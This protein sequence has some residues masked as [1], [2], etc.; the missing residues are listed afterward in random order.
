MRFSW[1]YNANAKEKSMLTSQYQKISSLSY[2]DTTPL[3]KPSFFFCFGGAFLSS[4]FQ[5]L[6]DNI[7]SSEILLISV[8]AVLDDAEGK[9]LGNPHVRKWLLQ[10]K[11]VIYTAEDLMIEICHECLPTD[12]EYESSSRPTKKS[13]LSNG[14][15]D[16][17][18]KI[19]YLLL[20]NDDSGNNIHV[21]PIVGMGGIGKTILARLVYDNDR[22]VEKSESHAHD[23]KDVTQLQEALKK[24]LKGRKFFFVLDEDVNNSKT[25]IINDRHLYV[26][27]RTVDS[28][29]F[30]ALS[31]P[32]Q[33]ATSRYYIGTFAE[34]VND[35]YKLKS[36]R[37]LSDFV[38]GKDNESSINQL[39]KLLQLHGTIRISGLE[40]IAG[41]GDIAETMLT[42]LKCI[43]ELIL[44]WNRWNENSDSNLERVALERLLPHTDLRIQIIQDVVTYCLHLGGYHLSR[45]S[46]S[47]DL[48]SW[49]E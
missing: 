37:F 47:V 25:P 34:N 18:E 24:A 15:D 30:E 17:K 12:V 42:D 39:Q 31:Q 33:L 29:E 19:I 10:L 14:R 26:K 49:K 11:E 22:G 23:N 7:A 1:T 28:R 38:V 40:N 36:L 4:L 3:S 41:V 48:M 13:Q 5:S 46:A 27:K 21:I 6:F 20:S 45:N 43:T 44:R 32:D 2:F 9:Q 8:E 16:D 35:L